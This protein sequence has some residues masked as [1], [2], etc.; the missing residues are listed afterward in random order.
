MG[1]LSK[2][3]DFVLNKDAHRIVDATSGKMQETE[4]VLKEIER[5]LKGNQDKVKHDR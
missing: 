5:L 3:V 1:V 2:I 4:Q